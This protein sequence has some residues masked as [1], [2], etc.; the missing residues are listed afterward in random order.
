MIKSLDWEIDP[1]TSAVK[2]T[3]TQDIMLQPIV[4]FLPFVNLQLIAGQAMQIEATK[5]LGAQ[6]RKVLP[7]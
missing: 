2:F 5:R 3:I 6:Q 7:V 4:F 1:N